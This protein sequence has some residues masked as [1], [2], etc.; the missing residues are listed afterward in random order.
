MVYASGMNEETMHYIFD[1]FHQGATSHPG[2]GNGPGSDLTLRVIE[3]VGGTIPTK[4]EPGKGTT[5]AVRLKVY[6]EINRPN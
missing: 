5:F 2:E 3:L 4:S 6:V 1:K